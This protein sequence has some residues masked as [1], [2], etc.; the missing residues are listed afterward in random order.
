MGWVYSVFL[1]RSGLVWLINVVDDFE[2][3][4][5]REAFMFHEYMRVL[6]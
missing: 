4:L 1:L 3:L 6:K 2:G 5:Y